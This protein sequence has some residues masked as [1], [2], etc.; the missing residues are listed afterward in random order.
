MKTA[1][2]H[3][4]DWCDEPIVEGDR[5]QRIRHV[6]TPGKDWAYFHFECLMRS[7]VGSVA[8]QTGRCSCYGGTGEDNPKLTIHQAA[9]DAFNHWKK[10]QSLDV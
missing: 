6:G 9:W 1:T 10:T 7:I 2:T 5:Y 3:T 8:H 4:C